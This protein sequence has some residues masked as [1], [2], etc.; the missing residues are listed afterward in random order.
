MKKFENLSVKIQDEI[1]EDIKNE[2][3]L[4]IQSLRLKNN[5]SLINKKNRAISPNSVKTNNSN[6]SN[7]FENDDI[8]EIIEE[9]DQTI[10]SNYLR[11]KTD[12]I[13]NKYRQR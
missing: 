3:N 13:M 1:T 5:Q 11:V 8:Q 12:E 4:S 9:E 10:T 7:L 6:N 2:D